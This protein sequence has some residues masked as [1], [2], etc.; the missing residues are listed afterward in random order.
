MPDLERLAAVADEELGV[1]G[2]R[3]LV[4]AEDAELADEGIDHDLEH[5]REHVL[6]RGRARERIC[7]GR[8][9]LALVEERRVAFGRVG[10]QLDDDV[11]QLGHA[12]A[13]ARR[14]EA[15]RDQMALAQRLLE[16]RVQLLGLDLALSRYDRHQLLVDLD[17][18]VDQRAV[19]LLDRGEVR[20]ARRVEEAVD[21]AL[22]AVRRAG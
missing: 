19:R 5:V 8:L 11:E 10:Q 22:A 3:A 4:H 13:G 9:A 1:L 2:D 16:R 18:L 6:L 14:H 7:C 15:H 21:D 17:H 12:G 20:L